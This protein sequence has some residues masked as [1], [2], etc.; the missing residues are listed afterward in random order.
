MLPELA[1]GR[2]FCPITE[3]NRSSAW[4][5][6][7]LAPQSQACWWLQ[8]AMKSGRNCLL[9]PRGI[10]L[11]WRSRQWP[12]QRSDKRS[13]QETAW[14]CDRKLSP[15]FFC[16]SHHCIALSACRCAPAAAL[17]SRRT[18]NPFFTPQL[19][20]VQRALTACCYPPWPQ[21]GSQYRGPGLSF[22]NTPAESVDGASFVDQTTKMNEMQDEIK[23]LRSL[24]STLHNDVQGTCNHHN[25]LHVICMCA[26][27]LNSTSFSTRFSLLLD[28][29]RDN[30]FLPLP[31]LLQ[32]RSPRTTAPGRCPRCRPS[33][34]GTRRRSC[35]CSARCSCCSRSSRAARSW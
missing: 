33:P 28:Q 25:N 6:V 8:L 31:L 11:G 19:P 15:H 23:Y 20:I 10:R 3:G 30:G 9:C 32:T 18:R 14:D 26:R 22:D 16:T 17:S 13:L 24:L 4:F 2:L 27:S 29:S 12:S 34:S 21:N 35:S 5:C 1:N 7:S